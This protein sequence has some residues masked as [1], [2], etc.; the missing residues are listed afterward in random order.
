MDQEQGHKSRHYV[1]L[2]SGQVLAALSWGLILLIALPSTREL[3]Q[4]GGAWAPIATVIT[5]Y[6]WLFLSIGTTATVLVVYGSWHSP[7]AAPTQFSRP[8]RHK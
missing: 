6:W 3:Q 4:S 8:S 7:D 2:R 1:A 5:T